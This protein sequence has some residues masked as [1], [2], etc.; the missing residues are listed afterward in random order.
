MWRDDLYAGMYDMLNEKMEGW[1]L[2]IMVM[3]EPPLFAQT[4]LETGVW[5]E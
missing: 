1:E 5:P 4:V 3:G 2:E